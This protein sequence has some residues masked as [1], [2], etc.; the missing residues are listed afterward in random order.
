MERL[1]KALNNLK[2]RNKLI[3]IYIGTGLIPVLILFSVSVMLMRSVLIDKE[4]ESLKGYLSQA[5]SALDNQIELYN[6]M[7]D[8]ISFNQTL[9]QVVTRKYDSTYER[10]EAVVNELE[11]IISSTRYLH[12]DIKRITIYTEN[13]IKYDT[14]LDIY[15]KILEE[16]WYQEVAQSNSIMWYVNFEEKNVFFVRKMPL[17]NKEGMKG[18]L[19]IEVDY[20]EFFSCFEQEIISNYGIYV[21][22]S[23]GDVL[24]AQEEGNGQFALTYDEVKDSVSHKE[25]SNYT[26]LSHHVRNL[27]W[28]V[29][30]YKSDSFAINSMEP[31]FVIF[32]ALLLICFASTWVA[33]R[34]TSSLISK[35]L[36][37]LAENMNQVE[38]GNL[39]L[40]V[41][42]D[43]TDEIGILIQGFERMLTELRRLI[44]EVF[45]SKLTQKE[46]E[47]RALQAQIN[48]HFLYNSLSIINWKAIEVGAMDISKVTLAL[49]TF[50]RTSLN[51]GSNVI[52]VADE[53]SNVKSYLLIQSVMHDDSFDIVYDID[54]EILDM[55]V[56]NLV[57]QPVA[58]NALEHGI[59]RLIDRKGLLTIRGYAEENLLYLIVEDNGDGM[60]EDMCHNILTNK[61][62]GYG[63]RNVHERIQLY[64]GVSYGITV[65]STKGVGTRV[66]LKF[67]QVYTVHENKEGKK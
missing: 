67:P 15:W 45:E 3:V 32:V 7:S 18:I 37:K 58:E 21:A 56:L 27:D 40:T 62:G 12:Q 63:M 50:Y 57:L 9:T 14:S 38:S 66:T 5:V 54:K 30:L 6:T 8:Y 55:K 2:L 36:E 10:Y 22:N 13:V 19:Y 34:S 17:L 33:L 25:R 4:K 39:A 42:D 52:S 59:D 46:Y 44:K 35:R 1:H 43:S 26:I 28:N 20:D 49:S 60:S 24:F 53:I 31:I 23:S 11:P 41:Q 48:P 47:M 65:E 51:K 29:Y 16:P 61:S 64:F